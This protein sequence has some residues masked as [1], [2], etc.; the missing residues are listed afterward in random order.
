MDEPA[1]DAALLRGLTQRRL[2]RGGMLR[3]LG[4]GAGALAVPSLLEACGTSTGTTSAAGLGSASWWAK[5][6]AGKQVNFA[7][8]PLYI[9]VAH[10]GGKSTHPSLDDFT[11]HTGIGVHYSEVIQAYDS[12]FGKI[13]PDLQAGQYTGYDLIVMGYPKWLPL[14]ISLKYLIP[15]DHG[16]MPNF[17][18]YAG[19][20]EKNPFYDP[21]NKYSVPW[22]SGITGIGYNPKLTGRK[23][24]SLHDLF[25]PAFKG[26]V[27]MFGDTEDLPNTALLAMGVDPPHST[28]KQWQQAANLLK[29]QKN[30]GIVRKY[31]DQSYINALTKGDTW[32]SMAWSGDIYQANLSGAPDLQFVVPKEGGLL[33]S[34]CMCI[35]QHSHNPRGAID[36]MDF[37][38][39]P[40]IAAMITEYVHYIAPVP[41]AKSVIRQDAAKASGK[42]RSTLDGIASSPLVF[43]SSHDLQR[44]HF[45]RNLTP[46]ETTQ[47]NSLFEPIYQS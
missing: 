45:Y 4:A 2:S 21:G 9:D 20:F 39:K 18:R 6:K 15:L 40:A 24:D 5:Q 26:R 35:P 43:P 32:L 22:Q 10:Q 31:Y 47:W 14:M 17:T 11:K 33:W 25:D 16:L 27:G 30:S 38:Y 46:K 29:K 44:L 34:D 37:V 19:A 12:F 36:L 1:I 42:Q 28:P 8:W 7:N 41:A 23:I 3:L 13:H